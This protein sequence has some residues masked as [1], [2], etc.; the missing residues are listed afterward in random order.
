MENE[1]IWI[2]SHVPGLASMLPG[3]TAKLHAMKEK[4]I[5]APSPVPSHIKVK[6]WD[7]SFASIWNGIVWLMLLN[8]FV[9]IVTA[10]AQRHLKKKQE[11]EM[12]TLTHSD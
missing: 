8:F 11:K 5:D 9:K 2:L 4:Y 3:L 7:F 10:T 1:L 6:K 12:A